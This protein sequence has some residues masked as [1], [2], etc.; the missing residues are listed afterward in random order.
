[1]KKEEQRERER[2]RDKKNV[3]EKTECPRALEGEMRPDGTI[4]ELYNLILESHTPLTR[5]SL[6]SFYRPRRASTRG[7]R[8]SRHEP[9]VTPSPNP[10]PRALPGIVKTKIGTLIT[11]QIYHRKYRECV[12]AREHVRGV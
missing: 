6:C 11:G 9:E 12:C 4:C 2:E 1:M 8:Q 5:R 10:A 3:R 7:A